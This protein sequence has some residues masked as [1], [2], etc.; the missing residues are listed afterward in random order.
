MEL[1]DYLQ[2]G[3][4]KTLEFK[5][6]CYTLKKII[7]TAV[8]FANTAGGTIVVGVKNNRDVVGVED[9]L[10]D[11]ERLSS[12]FADS[13]SP[14][15][16]PD[17]T[18]KSFRD[19]SVIIV[20]VFH[21]LA[22]YYVKA[23]G[24][25]EGVYIRLGSTNRKADL[26]TIENIKR[27]V[28]NLSYDELPCPDLN[29]EAIDFR[30]A[31]ELFQKGPRIIDNSALKTLGI[32]VEHG[33]AAVP[34]IGGVLLFG[35]HRKQYFPDAVIRCARFD[36]LSS[37]RF[38]DQLDI[39][40][41]LPQAVEST[42]SFIRK[43]TRIGLDINGIKSEETPEYPL[44]AVRE[45]VVNALVHTDYSITGANIRVAIFDDRIEISNPGCLPFGQTLESAMAGTSKLRNRVI[46]R[47][48]KE[49]K[50]IEQW[51]TGI[52]RIITACAKQGLPE[53]LFEELGLSFRVTLFAWKPQASIL[54]VWHKALLDYL[55]A[56][57]SISTKDAAELWNTTDRTARSRLKEM[58]DQGLILQL[59]TSPR[60]PKKVYVLHN[61]SS[62]V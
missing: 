23:E 60:D 4:G 59:G 11:E 35:Y 21:S 17:I 32:L 12:A 49:L 2:Q 19:R 58:L 33:K 42:M 31:S 36:G 10:K 38:I 5:E 14:L 24:P 52:K 44:A 26:E 8:A 46:G 7:R 40:E 13:V 48:F 3:E 30:V 57:D 43:N 18:I 61:R 27:G 53:P 22:P 56:H 62:R 25:E 41:Y 6:N 29:S 39:D 54:P 47:V 37:T 20:K 34:T 1:I 51:G 50:L 15:L 45:A 28:R 55:S 16:I 9:P